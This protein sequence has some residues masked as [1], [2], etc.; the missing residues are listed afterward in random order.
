M[1]NEQAV[2]KEARRKRERGERLCREFLTTFESL[3]AQLGAMRRD[4]RGAFP[5]NTPRERFPF[6]LQEVTPIERHARKL[7]FRMSDALERAMKRY[8]VGV[9]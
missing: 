7:H 5:Q 2:F 1:S 3:L 9:E 4:A 8:A 6:A